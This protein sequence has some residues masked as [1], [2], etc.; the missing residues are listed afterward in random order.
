MKRTVL[1]LASITAGL[2]L[3]S[4]VALGVPNEQAR[5]SFPGMNGKI[6]FV[7]DPDGYRGKADPEI[8][9]IWFDGNNL[10]RLTNNSR[11]DSAPACRPV[12]RR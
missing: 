11:V 1:L 3:A 12:V 5:A 4:L 2:V 10:K 9:T 8:Y 7:R 6:A